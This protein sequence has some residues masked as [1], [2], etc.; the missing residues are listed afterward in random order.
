MFDYSFI[1]FYLKLLKGVEFINNYMYIFF[2]KFENV[3][4]NKI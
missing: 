1:C 3:M 2:G 4:E